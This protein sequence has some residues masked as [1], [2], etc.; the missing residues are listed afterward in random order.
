M[1]WHAEYR[2]LYMRHRIPYD[3]ENTEMTVGNIFIRSRG[4]IVYRIADANLTVNRFE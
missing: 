4:V 3:S 1:K 2:T